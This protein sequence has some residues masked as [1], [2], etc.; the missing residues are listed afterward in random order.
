M[1]STFGFSFALLVPVS[2]SLFPPSR[3]TR[4]HDGDTSRRLGHPQRISPHCGVKALLFSV[5]RGE[6]CS[7]FLARADLTRHRRALPLHLILPDWQTVPGVPVLRLGVI[8]RCRQ[9]AAR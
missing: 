2:R 1:I 8:R 9:G 3:I 5:T 6:L 7:R 4:L